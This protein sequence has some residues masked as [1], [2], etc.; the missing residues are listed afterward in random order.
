Q[1]E[2]L[3]FGGG[4]TETVLHPA[5]LVALLCAIVLILL[6]RRRH[7]IVP[8][9]LMAFLVPLGQQVVVGG[10]HVF[11]LRIVLFV[12]LL[13]MLFSMFFSQAHVFS[14]GVNSLDKVFTLWAL[15]HVIAFLF[16]FSFQRAALVN[17][18]GFLWDAMGGFLL[19]RF[20]IQDQ[21]DIDR[22][23]R[24]FAWIAGILAL[25]MLNEHFRMQ[26]VFGLL[27]GV[28]TVPETRDGLVRA[29][30]TFSHPL[31]AGTFGAT[32]LPLF[33][34][35]WHS[36][37]SK[38]IAALGVLSATIM[39]LCAASSTPVLAYAAAIGAVCFWPFRKHM[40]LLRWGIVF[41]LLALHVVMK[42]PVWFLI[43]RIAVLGASSGDHRAYLV[44][45]FIR[46]IGDWW[47]VG[48]NANGN[49]GWDMWDTSN[50][51]VAEGESGGLVVFVCFLAM[52]SLCFRRIG[53]ARKAVEG[54][55]GKEWCFWFLG[56]AL[57]AHIVAFFGISYFDQTRV[58]WFALMAMILA[59]TGPVL[60]AKAQP[61]WQPAG[62][63]LASSRLAYP[64]S[65]SRHER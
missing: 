58:A 15:F 47:L 25:G 34:L 22:V 48:T 17:Q 7:A 2:N 33:L 4:A 61:D 19:L 63:P 60:A 23:V 21:E 31:L 32:L 24:T 52:I 64:F 55:R 20:L 49:W 50:Q 10:V 9:L 30:G 14:G 12:G 54:D 6:L 5:V 53:N 13:R 65:I 36:G 11:V 44:D 42:A 39:T 8:V 40:R 28:L 27:G 37:K 16:L 57:F 43:N 3:K 51:Y 29:Q 59:A 38:A 26:N 41:A 1:P 45:L 35:L 18:F 62:S 56:A 46:H